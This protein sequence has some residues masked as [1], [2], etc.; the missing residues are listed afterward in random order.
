MQQYLLFIDTETS[1]L[2]KNWNLPYSDDKNWPHA[3][4]ISWIIYTS[5]Q[6]EVKREDHYIKD[7]DFEINN[8]AFKIHGITR[9]FLN[10]H[11]VYRKDVLSSLADDLNKYQ[12]LV[13]GHFVELDFH[14]TGADF[15]RTG[16]SQPMDSLQMY[17]TMLGTTNFLR[18][19]Q[20]RY[21]KLNQLYSL[22][23]NRQLSNHH[24]AMVDAL[25]TAECFFELVR[26]GSIDDD[27]IA[28]QQVERLRTNKPKLQSGCGIPAVVLFILTILIAH[29]L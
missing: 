1:G 11:G 19:P 17:C 23:F 4:Q 15:Y 22:L 8:E 6:V 12:P 26:M 16:I 18:N 29:W 5:D 20:T 21:L 10:M 13:V 2:P 9:S 14:I 7:D 27:K 24:N 3:V 25:A 28:R